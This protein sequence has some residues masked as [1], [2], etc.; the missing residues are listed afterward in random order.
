[1]DRLLGLRRASALI[2]FRQEIYKAFV[3]HQPVEEAFR[4]TDIDLSL[5]VSA[6]DSTWTDRILI[7]L[8]DAL[9]FCFGPRINNSAHSTRT[10]EDIWEYSEEWYRKKPSSFDLVHV[11]RPRCGGAEGHSCAECFAPARWILSETAVTGLVNFHLFR[12]LMLS[13]DPGAPRLGPSRARYLAAQEKRIKQELTTLI[14]LTKGNSQ[15]APLFAWAGLGIA[16][17]G[18]RFK[19]PWEH[20]QLM[21]I[22]K[23]AEVR[24]GWNTLATQRNLMQAWV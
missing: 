6:G 22:L 8:A 21:D 19:E 24:H 12:I 18:D 4:P 20:E 17:A 14:S 11:E 9:D 15:C 16:M 3:I 1:M 7:K 2:A 23:D 10:F 5:D 13:F